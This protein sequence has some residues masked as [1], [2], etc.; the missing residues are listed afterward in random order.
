MEDFKLGDEAKKLPCRHLFHEPCISEWL[1][2]HGTCPVCRKNLNGEDTS[3]REYITPANNA[4]DANNSASTASSNPETS[5]NANSNSTA[6]NTTNNT[7][8]NAGSGNY[9][10]PDM[11]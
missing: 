10:E 2:L 3:Q 5:S 1:K 7:N 11:D 4:N 9:Y 6:S 8:S